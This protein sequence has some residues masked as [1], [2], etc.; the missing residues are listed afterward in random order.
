M[1]EEIVFKLEVDDSGA[2]KSLEKAEDGVEGIGK[3]AKK[4]EK[5]TK[6]F[7]KS[8]SNL[9][10]ASGIVGVLVFAF[11]ALKEA[12]GNN[13]SVMDALSTATTAVSIIFND[14]FSL[15]ADNF[16]PAVEYVTG[17]FSDI[18]ATLEKV[19]QAIYENL[20]VRFNAL[21]KTFGLLGDAIT[22][23]F[24]G[25]FSG[26]MDSASEA[27]ETYVDVLTGVEGTVGKV[28]DGV[29]ALVDAT[30]DYATETYNAADA[31]TQLTKS[32]ALLE[33]QQTRVREQ[34]D[35]DAERQRQIRDDYT[36]GIDER[37]E[38]NK[39]LAVILEEQEAAEKK[40]VTDR[41]AALQ[42][43]Q[44]QL[45]VTEARRLE[46]F[47]LGTELLAIE[48]QQEGFRS[49][50]KINAIALDKEKL[51]LLGFQTQAQLDAYNAEQEG[52]AQLDKAR[53]DSAKAA[54]K[55]AADTKKREDDLAKSKIDAAIG[56]ANTIATLGEEG[57]AEAKAAAVASTLL[58]T[59][60]GIQAA[61]AQTTGG[62]GIKLAAAGVAAA[63]GIANLQKI[64]N[65]PTP[66]NKSTSASVSTATVAAPEFNVEQTNQNQLA[67]SISGQL[68]NQ[69]VK[70]YVVGSEVTSQQQMDRVQL[71]N[72]TL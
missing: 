5:S 19:K 68:N 42:L 12:L 63:F 45:G 29:T 51:E 11:E 47:Q 9:G 58:N 15:I 23:V 13:Q 57:S 28:V 31:I 14:L 71:N 69:P 37:I 2:V 34:S 56:V 62:I 35:R 59:Y 38:A 6:G 33:A 4:T 64:L 8:L 41:I 20:E 52:L 72:A 27:A 30:I 24:S 44:Q 70:A 7:G 67:D 17:L 50:Q 40:T 66:G 53:A 43:E 3:A 49:E 61:F 32:S 10:K 46:I 22:K 55:I 48:A 18:P 36:K 1:A 39:K 21:I 26:A 60:A 16:T 54:A 25:D 65:T